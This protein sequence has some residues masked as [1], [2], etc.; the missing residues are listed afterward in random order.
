MKII[1]PMRLD[2]FA[3]MIE[4]RN[5]EMKLEQCKLEINGNGSRVGGLIDNILHVMAFVCGN[6]GVTTHLLNMFFIKI[7]FFLDT[8]CGTHK[9]GV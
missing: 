3:L 6:Y 7:F 4:Y 2:E 9:P 5:K 1:F 8:Q